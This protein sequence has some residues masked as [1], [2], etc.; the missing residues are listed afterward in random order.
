MPRNAAVA[1]SRVYQ[2]KITLK[3]SKPPIGRRVEVADDIT[4]ARL[5]HIAEVNVALRRESAVRLTPRA[6]GRLRRIVEKRIRRRFTPA[7]A[8]TA[9][10]SLRRS[11]VFRVVELSMVELVYPPPAHLVD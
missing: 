4:L 10:Q 11:S 7:C 6:R 2:R 3:E 5:H 9:I 1:P 8:G